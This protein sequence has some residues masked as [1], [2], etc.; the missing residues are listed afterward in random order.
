MSAARSSR[1]IRKMSVTKDD[2]LLRLASAGFQARIC[3]CQMTQTN[4]YRST[5]ATA[6]KGMSSRSDL[7]RFL[8]SVVGLFS[9]IL[10]SFSVNLAPIG[11]IFSA[12]VVPNRRMSSRRAI[13]VLVPLQVDAWRSSRACGGS[14]LGK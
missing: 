13:Y 5:R 7:M 14:W 12:D 3:T 11:Q 8:A 4:V 6:S 1:F 9:I 2:F 10:V